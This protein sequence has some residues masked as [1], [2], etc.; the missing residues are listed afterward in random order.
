MADT[1]PPVS[2]QVN[3]APMDAP[4]ARHV[5][6][7]QLR[8]LLD[9]VDDVVLSVDSAPN[10]NS[11][12]RTADYQ[13]KQ[14]DLQRLLDEVCAA[15]E[16]VR[17]VAV[18]YSAESRD[19]VARY[20]SASHSLPARAGDGSPFHAYLHGVL[21][22]RFDH[23]LH[24]DSD[25]FLGGGSQ[26]WVAAALDV[27]RRDDRVLAVNP[28]PGPPHEDGQLHSQP[29]VAYRDRPYSFQFDGVS[30]RVFLL[31]RSRFARRELSIDALRPDRMRRV[32]AAINHT[33]P[34]RPLED[35][36]GAAMTRAGMI[37]V[38]I[39][40]AEPG[41]WSL[42]PDG[43]SPSFY[44]ALPHLVARVEAGDVPPGQRG[45]HDVTDYFFDWSEYR[46]ANTRARRVARNLRWAAAGLSDRVGLARPAG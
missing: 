32:R 28:L 38:D 41:L 19:S 8:V 29:G 42:H 45:C 15:H 16:K 21:A 18:D 44:A 36:L 9:Q 7:H 20:F 25:L 24:L 11:R 37:R 1:P 17:V 40:G 39:L 46:A 30:T 43:R 22:A 35:C 6:P 4:H 12:Y 13:A 2:L 33:P 34:V 10:Q 14:A 31:D 5:L 26:G 3:L 23:V 27:L